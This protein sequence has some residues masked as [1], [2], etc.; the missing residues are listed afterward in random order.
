[1]RFGFDDVVFESAQIDH[2]G[3]RTVRVTTA[4]QRV[5]VCPECTAVSTM[6]KSWITT[7]RRDIK[8]GPDRPAAEG[9]SGND[10]ASTCPAAHVFRLRE[11]SACGVPHARLVVDRFHLVQKTNAMVDTVRRRVTHSERGRRGRTSDVE[12]ITRRRL[13]RAAERL[14]EEQRSKLFEKLTGADPNGDIAAAR[15]VKDLLRDVLS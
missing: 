15:T 14:T 1:M 10:C 4:A 8:L 2:D 9:V 5:G 12:W 11:G 13:L 3:I 7:R 6:S